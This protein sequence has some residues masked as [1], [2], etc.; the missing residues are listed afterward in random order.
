MSS[1]ASA[2]VRCFGALAT[3][4]SLVVGLPAQAADE[5]DTGGIFTATV[6]PNRMWWCEKWNPDFS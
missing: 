1:F 3:L 6:P 5:P 2:P 4:V